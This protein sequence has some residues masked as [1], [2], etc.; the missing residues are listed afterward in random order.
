SLL[1][2]A[3]TK[4]GQ[5]GWLAG[6]TLGFFAAS[7]AL[8]VGFVVWELRHREPL[9]RLGILR[10]KTV[11]GANV[12]GFILGTATFSMFLMLTLYMQQ[13]LGYS[14]LKTG[15]G[16]LAVAGGAIV[17]SA[18]AAQI[19]N[20]IGVK[21]ALV[22]G[23]TSLTAGLVYFTQVSV[24]GSYL[25]DL[26]PGFLLV[27]V[28]LG[29]SFVPIS[30]AALELLELL[31]HHLPSALEEV[32]HQQKLLVGPLLEQLD[33]TVEER[34]VERRGLCSSGSQLDDD[35]PAILAVAYPPGIP[36]CLE[37]IDE[38][39]DRPA[40]QVHGLREL[41]CGHRTALAED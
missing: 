26:L 10:I 9:M 2:Y 16:Y 39:R 33:G 37:A 29:F 20:R 1:V 17:T 22:I 40:G 30:I 34:F 15:V 27:A 11:T 13:V 25:G 35:A 36:G 7:V 23:M 14:P 24:G 3:I 12:A 4:A 28:G 18:I 38:S 31:L 6:T 32:D 19:V 21:P 5:D 41:A 8:L